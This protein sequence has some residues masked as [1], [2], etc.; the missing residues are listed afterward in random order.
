MFNAMA[1]ESAP[2]GDHS[3]LPNQPL[4]KILVV[5]DNATNQKV[6]L[7]QLQSL[8]YEADLATHGQA[9]LDLTA[10]TFYAMVLMDCRLPGIDGYHATRLI[11]QREQQSQQ[12]PKAII[13]A[14][15]ANNEP[16]A[17]TEA[18]AVG[19]DDFLTKPLRR[20]TLAAALERWHKRFLESALR[21]NQQELQQ[22]AANQ[23]A[24][25]QDFQQAAQQSL[26]SP[27]AL[28]LALRDLQ[29]DLERLHQLSDCNLEF[30]QE[31]LRLYLDDTQTQ[32]QQLRQ[33]VACQDFCQIEQL[34][35]HIKGSSASVGANQL[36]QLAEALEQQAKQAQAQEI[37]P[38]LIAK[39]ELQIVQQFEQVR[40]RIEGRL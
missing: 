14:L 19:M 28:E 18:I 3:L 35:H 23:T 2:H 20:E 25:Q 30:E 7:R 17:E 24:N 36:E 33:G 29:F 9:A 16:E 26:P 38:E 11:R 22:T 5:E 1:T 34:A 27:V 10:H 15:T 37:K 31:L 21:L 8:G 6:I 39:L 4:F 12:Y 13:I 32:L 40:L